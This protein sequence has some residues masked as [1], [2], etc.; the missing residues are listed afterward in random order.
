MRNMTQATNLR[1]LA[2]EFHQALP[3]RIREYLRGRGIPDAVVDRHLLGWNGWRITI[4]ITNRED[5]ITFFKFAK[6]PEDQ[7]PGPKMLTSRGATLE[8]YGW[9]D[10]LAKP[11]Q[12]IICEGEFDRLVLK[13][14]GFHAVTSTGGAGTFRE[15]WAAEFDEIQ[16]VYASFDRDEAGRRGALRVGG[17]IPHAKIVE[18]PEEVGE[19]GDVT[20]FFA[21]LGQNDAAFLELL[22]RAEAVPPSSPAQLDE[23]LQTGQK[24]PAIRE[25]IEHI[26]R[27]VPIGDLVGRYVRLRESGNACFGICPFHEDRL[28]SLTVYPES[29]RFYCYG[30]LKQGDVIT[31]LRE[32]EQLSFGEAL[33]RLENFVT[34]HG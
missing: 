15:A 8:L 23:P 22:K 19:G 13:A 20:D 24:D 4:P 30:C 25:R 16:E 14:Q 7:R 9:E 2:R 17:L 18:L 3:V 29:G 32:M 34:Y 5:V 33:D 28:P 10:V 12:I 11:S 27:A 26:K 1:E 21:R 6:D 31:F